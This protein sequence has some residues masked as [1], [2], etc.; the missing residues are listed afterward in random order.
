M[1]TRLAALN[2]FLR[3][4]E[5]PRL[6]RTT[7][8]EAARARLLHVTT[9]GI[10][11]RFPARRVPM[12]EVT[13][14]GRPAM[15]IPPPP[16]GRLLLWFHG[17]AYCLG[18]HRTHASFVAA[19]AARAGVGMVLPDYRLAPEHPF[20][21]APQDALAA[22][23]ALR[24]E[25]IAASSILLGGDSAGGGLAFVLLA[26]LLAAGERP[27]GLLAF[28]PWTDL[29]LSGASLSANAESDSLLPAERLAEVRDLYLAGAD[30]TDPRASP[31]F[32]HFH[33]APPVLVQAGRDEILADDARRIVARLQAEGAE[34][35]LE[36]VPAVPHVWQFWHALV[37]EAAAALDRAAGFLRDL[38]AEGT[39]SGSSPGRD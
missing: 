6:A 16:G 1:S 20:P 11:G 13:L 21:A 29:T 26:A 5:K 4:R 28:S 34:A 10:A 3:L 38:P 18:S 22:W 36:L 23:G 9:A 39:R 2:L 15:R 31:Q 8:V 30:P 35:M 14:A 25:G 17:G 27:A 19:L 33:G 7:S 32:A 12:Q 37:P 24:A